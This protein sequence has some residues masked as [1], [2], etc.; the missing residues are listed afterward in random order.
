MTP[1]TDLQ[2]FRAALPLLLPEHEGQFVVM[3]GGKPLHYSLAYAD[4]LAWAYEHLGLERFFVKQ[5]SAIEEIAHFTRD[6]G[7]CAR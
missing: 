6:L 5:V 2:A 7:A 1:Q 3:Q 4:A